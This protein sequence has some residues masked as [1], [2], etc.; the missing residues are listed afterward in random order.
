MQ[1]EAFENAG[2]WAEQHRQPLYGACSNKKGALVKAPFLLTQ[3]N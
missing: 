1:I 3:L 2:K